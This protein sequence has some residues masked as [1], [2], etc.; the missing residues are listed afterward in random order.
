MESDGRKFSALKSSIATL[1]CVP[2]TPVHNLM[3]KYYRVQNY[4]G[5]DFKVTARI[6]FTLRA[7]HPATFFFLPL[8]SDLVLEN[9]RNKRTEESWSHRKRKPFRHAIRPHSTQNPHSEWNSI[10]INVPIERKRLFI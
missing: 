8:S 6:W 7:T 1:N 3:S 4:V 5:C 10:I 9:E 2:S